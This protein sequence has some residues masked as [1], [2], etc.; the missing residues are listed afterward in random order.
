MKLTGCKIIN[1]L[2]LDCKSFR[3]CG[4][5]CSEIKNKMLYFVLFVTDKLDI[6]WLKKSVSRGICIDSVAIHTTQP[7]RD[8]EKCI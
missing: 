4:F 6:V 1:T 7:Q 5:G 2:Y 8:F 3:N